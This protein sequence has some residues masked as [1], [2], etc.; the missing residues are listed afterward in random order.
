[1]WTKVEILKNLFFFSGSF[2]AD[3]CGIASSYSLD[4]WLHKKSGQLPVRSEQFCTSSKDNDHSENKIQLSTILQSTT[5]KLKVYSQLTLK[6]VLFFCVWFLFYTVFICHHHLLPIN[7]YSLKLSLFL[8]SFGIEYLLSDCWH[9][10]VIVQ[11]R[12]GQ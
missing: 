6:F 12:G 4:G 1:M 2:L 7:V 3:W 9:W 5:A 10:S 8:S 11:D